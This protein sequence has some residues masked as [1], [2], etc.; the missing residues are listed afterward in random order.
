M[1][2]I[3]KGEDID[4]KEVAILE[5][6]KTV[7]QETMPLV[8]QIIELKQNGNDAEANTLLV[9]KASPSF[10]NWLKVI[11]EFI[12]YEEAK[13]QAAT[14]LARDIANSFGMVMM[15]ILL[16]SL[17]VAVS[18]AY[19]ISKQLSD[20]ANTLQGGLEHFFRFL[21]KE[22]TIAKNIELNSSDEF[23][24]MAKIINLNIQKT[25]ANITKDDEF[26]VDVARFINELSNGNM[27]A[28]LEKESDTPSLIELKK[29]LVHLQNYLE[30]TIARDL[31]NL[32]Q[33]LESYKQQDFTAR[34]PNAYAKVALIVNDLGDVIS[35]L[36]MESLNIGNTL[37]KSSNNLITNVNEL[38]V[39]ASSA[40]ASLEETAASLEE[41]TSNIRHNTQSIAKM[42]T[43][44]DNVTNSARHGEKLANDTT[45]AMEEINTQV[46]AIN[47]AIK[48]IDQIAFQTNILSLNAAVEAATAGEAGKGFAVVAG[49]VRNLASRSSD[50]A[51]EIKSI[52]INAT[53]KANDGK[54][55]ANEMIKGYIE[56]NENINQTINL[57]GDIEHASKEQLSGIEQINDAVNL[58][59]QQ[60]QRNASIAN[61]TKQIALET[62]KIAQNIVKEALEKKFQGKL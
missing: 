56:L 34:F 7:E 22:S 5:K 29:L 6:I 58:L 23:G 52:V 18:V 21:N 12:D 4:S 49:E 44:A 62:D 9:E 16:I 8:K 33:V 53:N 15:T 60:T 39:S 55:I 43:L 31:N 32:I 46:N 57:I 42:A 40:A 2:E 41:M 50:A 3:F 10:T 27:L 61:Q 25:S 48:V 28:K 36:L 59:D 13:N 19:F 1:D 17:I 51:N 30:H 24:K 35:A 47:E 20:S 45:Q 26:V 54:N 38:N 11:N 14:P 37:E